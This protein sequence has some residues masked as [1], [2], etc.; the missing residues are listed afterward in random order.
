[1]VWV[2]LHR[3]FIIYCM[4]KYHVNNLE[5]NWVTRNAQNLQI[6]SNSNHPFLA[7]S[8]LVPLNLAMVSNP[9]ISSS[10]SFLFWFQSADLYFLSFSPAFLFA[11]LVFPPA[12]LFAFLVFPPLFEFLFFPLWIYFFSLFYSSCVLFSCD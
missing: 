11:F 3:N 8:Y 2:E 6:L 5:S 1:M 4:F 12:F 10:A 9:S 7:S